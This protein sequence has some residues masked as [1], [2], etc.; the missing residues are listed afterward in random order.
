[1]SAAPALAPRCCALAPREVEI[2]RKV[3]FLA[4]PQV[5]AE[6]PTRLEM[7]ETH[8][9]WL[10]L[11]DQHVYKLKKP[12]RSDGADFTT[13][14]ARQRNAE[15]EVR[16][17]RRLA[18]NVYL[19]IV[20]LT[21]VGGRGLAIGGEGVAV[22]WLVKMVRL[23][24]EQM[25]DRRLACGDWHYADI[26]ALADFLAK[27]FATAR[28]VHIPPIAYLDRFR[29]ECQVSRRAFRHS[30]TPP[31]QHSVDCIV[32]AIEAF[33]GR[34]NELL[35]Q[36]LERRRIVE[37]HGDLRPEHISLGLA[38]RIIDC[39]EFRFDLRCLDP[40]DELAF[41]AMEC[42]RL[43][44][45]GIARVLFWHYCR[46]TRDCPPA[47]LIAFYKVIGALIRARIAI[48]HLQE[49][50]VRDPAKWPKRAAD[51]LEIAWRECQRLGL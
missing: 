31:L 21:M 11:T 7:F 47:V 3:A 8:F 50:P 25:L 42:E 49:T 12:L 9:S 32:R 20:P 46:R 28:R 24:A 16:L 33:I 35:L 29:A 44:A 40:V 37:G 27:F 48:L 2:A 17:N 34:H 5:Y 22:D 51:Y 38:P 1:M 30:G 41:L 6:R 18:A 13:S 45:G 36:R 14:K 10:F 4:L 39:L 43:G 23:P 19:G 26:Y 15:A